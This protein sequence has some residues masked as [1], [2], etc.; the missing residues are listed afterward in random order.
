VLQVIGEDYP[1]FRCL[2]RTN[3][4]GIPVV[5]IVTEAALTLA[6]ILTASST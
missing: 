5:A 4:E 6:F 3:R 2:S 1:L